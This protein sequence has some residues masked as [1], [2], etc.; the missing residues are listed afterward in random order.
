MM[1]SSFII[2]IL[3]AIIPR[4][5]G[6][7]LLNILCNDVPLV[8]QAEL[9]ELIATLVGILHALK[10]YFNTD[11]IISTLIIITIS[12]GL[13]L[14]TIYKNWHLPQNEILLLTNQVR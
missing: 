9:Y 1:F 10:F 3:M 7:V 14:C 11:N 8:F 4:V 2:A 6:G 12:F 5:S 13:I